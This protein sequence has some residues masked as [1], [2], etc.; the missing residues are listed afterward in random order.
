MTSFSDLHAFCLYLVHK[1]GDPAS[2][3]ED[4]KAE[5]FETC[6]DLKLR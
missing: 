3:N 1:H 4:E 6:M 5:S 2:L